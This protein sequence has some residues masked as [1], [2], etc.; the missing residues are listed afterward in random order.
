VRIAVNQNGRWAPHFAYLRQAAKAGLLGDVM[1]AHLSVHKNC[2][3][4]FQGIANAC[5][6]AH[7][8]RQGLPGLQTGEDLC[9]VG[10]IAE[11]LKL[12]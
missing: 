7:R 10:P 8:R 11:S 4:A 9:N 2:K 3:G 5:L 1:A 6:L 12:T